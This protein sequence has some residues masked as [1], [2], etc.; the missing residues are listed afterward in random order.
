MVDY[1]TLDSFGQLHY[2][3][4]KDYLTVVLP[5]VRRHPHLKVMLNIGG[6]YAF[7]TI[8]SIIGYYKIQNTSR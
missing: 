6:P 8:L 2:A 3:Y 4:E 1:V 5:V 7:S